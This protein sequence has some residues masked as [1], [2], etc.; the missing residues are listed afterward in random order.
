M[1]S[2]DPHNLTFSP[3]QRIA[4]Q[5]EITRLTVTGESPN[6]LNQFKKAYDISVKQPV[7]QMDYVSCLV[8]FQSIRVILLSMN[9]HWRLLTVLKIRQI[10]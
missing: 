10:L 8:L 4:T 9:V 1:K 7:Q 6:L 3:R 2:T 5:R